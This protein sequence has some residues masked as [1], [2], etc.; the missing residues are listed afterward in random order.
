MNEQTRIEYLK[1]L[2]EVLPEQPG[3]Y[4]YFNNKGEIIYVGKAKNLKR[5][6]SS[7]FVNTNRHT[8]KTSILVSKI[9]DIKHIIVNSENDAFLLENNLI[10]KLK[11]RYNILLKDDKTYPWICIKNEPYPRV[12]TTRNLVKDGSIYFGPYTSLFQMNFLI[13]L[14]HDIYKIRTCKLRLTESD[15]EKQKYKECLKYHINKCCAPCINKTTHDDYTNRI[16]SIQSILKGNLTEI[17][18]KTHAEMIQASEELNFEYAESLKHIIDSITNYQDKSTVSTNKKINVSVF[19]V[20]NDSENK[21]SF[22]NYTNV[23]EGKIIESYTMTFKHY[24]NEE[25]SEIISNAIQET[26]NINKKL[27]KEIITNSLPDIQF[28]GYNIHIPTSGDKRKILELSEKN[29]IQYK[30]EKLKNLANKDGYIKGKEKILISIKELLNLKE[31]PKHIEIFDNSN[32]QGEY[33]VGVCVV[34]KNGKPSKNDYRKYDIKTVE[35]PDD[36]ASMY[37]VVYRRYS[38]LLKENSEIPTLI[39]ADGGL[40]QMTI[41]NSVLQELKINTNIIGLAKNKSH[42]TNEILYE[43]PPQKINISRNT[44]VFK[45]FASMQDEVHRFAIDFHRKKRNKSTKYS[46]LDDIK[47]I[48]TKTKEKIIRQYKN[49]E[50]IRDTDINE[51]SKI[52]GYKKAVLVKEYLKENYK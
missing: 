50:K 5:R 11:P 14:V 34:Y 6:V 9:Y 18:K 26:L 22:V 4:Q 46:I 51:L 27:H 32:I 40:G 35:G 42:K 48:G 39:V 19:T 29:A 31:L 17:I 36:Y 43:L 15:I 7:Y 20:T 44:E 30:I 16:L 12:F 2:I 45:F 47:G 1:S 24:L 33:A 37:E 23:T 25:N 3:V 52:I 8:L 13:N 49:I 21:N 10:K 28:E 38:R 41:I